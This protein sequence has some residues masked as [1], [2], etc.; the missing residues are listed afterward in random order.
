MMIG[1]G[2][3]VV[4]IHII[5]LKAEILSQ[6]MTKLRRGLCGGGHDDTIRLEL[7]SCVRAVNIRPKCNRGIDLDK[8]EA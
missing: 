8:R 4:Q 5:C 1:K 6:L 3:T 2:P 7:V